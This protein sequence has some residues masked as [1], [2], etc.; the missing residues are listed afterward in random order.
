[1]FAQPSYC[2]KYTSNGVA[3]IYRTQREWA[4]GGGGESAETLID[5]T[6]NKKN[7]GIYGVRFYAIDLEIIRCNIIWISL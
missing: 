5:N 1:M 7:F 2:Q 3:K 6:N 4:R